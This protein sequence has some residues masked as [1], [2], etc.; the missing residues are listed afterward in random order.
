MSKKCELTGKI[1]LKGHNVSHANNKT[2]RRF[3]INIHS[4]TLNSTTLGERFKVKIAASTMRT[5]N[6]LGGLERFLLASDNSKL[7]NEAIKIKNKL[8]KKLSPNK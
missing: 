1:P 4:V 3:N 6:K 2:K 5:L 7:S 8:S